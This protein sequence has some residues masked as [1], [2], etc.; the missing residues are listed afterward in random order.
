PPSATTGTSAGRIGGL[1]AWT[2]TGQYRRLHIM[3]SPDGLHYDRDLLLP[4][5]AI[6]R[7]SVIVA[8]VRD[9]E[10]V[11]LAWTGIDSEHHLN[12]MYDV[13]GRQH[14]LS[15]PQGSPY[16]P[17]LALFAGRLWLAWTGSESSHA[18]HIRALSLDGQG[19]VPGAETI[20]GDYRSLAAP[21][22]APNASQHQ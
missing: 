4:A 1:L 5:N 6:A 13:L 2:D 22:L 19:L 9:A 18:L 20:L 8:P 7:P 10:V 12:V 17:S 11:I 16:A 14:V 15:L 21:S 3:T